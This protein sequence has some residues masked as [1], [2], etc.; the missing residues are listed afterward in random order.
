MY[1]LSILWMS[2]LFIH[3]KTEIL[4]LLLHYS[5]FYTGTIFSKSSW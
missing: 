1:S 4:T 5:L 2:H 3:L